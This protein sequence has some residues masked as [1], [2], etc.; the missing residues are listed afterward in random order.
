VSLLPHVLGLDDASGRWYLWWSGAGSD[1]SELAIVGV[2]AAAYRKHRCHVDRCWRPGVYPVHGTPYRACRRHHPTV[3][4]RVSA[5]HVAEAHA[6]Q[7]ARSTQ[8]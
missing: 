5:A 2:L 4:A 3:P 8:T 6:E 1:L 7:A